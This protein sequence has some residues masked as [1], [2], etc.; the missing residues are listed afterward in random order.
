[1][2]SIY[3]IT[4]ELK[5]IY[6]K[7]ECGEGIDTETGEIKP[8]IVNTLALTQQN[9]QTKAVDYGYVIKSFD[10]EIDIYDR[11][12][13]RLQERK[14]YL[15]NTQNRLKQTLSNA[16]QE[17]NIVEIKGET[18]RLSF[19]ES[20]S[21]EITD[22]SLLDEQYKRVKVEPD[23]TAIKKALKNGEDVQGAR[24]VK[25]QNLQIK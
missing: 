25:N 15:K 20:E 7:L 4:N 9:L 19:R 12:I 2:G 6:D 24:L 3:N 18:L 5:Q 16:M 14:E 11:E 10:D 23:K 1:M 17:F 21:V 8:E 13:K 22:E